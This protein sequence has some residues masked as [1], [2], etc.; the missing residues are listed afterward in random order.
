M[1]TT[2]IRVSVKTR[3]MLNELAQAIGL[4]MQKVAEQ[5]IE[6]YRREYFLNAAN[7]AYAKLREDE[8]AWQTYQEEIQEWDVSLSDGL[9]GLQ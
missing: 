6:Q 2:T 1:S 3:N 5:A 9:E 7:I 8:P 4:P